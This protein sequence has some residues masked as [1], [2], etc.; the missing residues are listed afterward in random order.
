MISFQEKLADALWSIME[1]SEG[2][3]IVIGKFG[4]MQHVIAGLK[5]IDKQLSKKA[6][7][8]EVP[9]RKIALATNP[10]MLVT[11]DQASKLYA[12]GT[13]NCVTCKY[14]IA[15]QQC[16]QW[17][18][19]NKHVTINQHTADKFSLGGCVLQRLIEPLT[20]GNFYIKSTDGPD[21]DDAFDS[22]ISNDFFDS[23]VE[24]AV[25]RD[26]VI[27]LRDGKIKSTLSKR[28]LNIND[29]LDIEVEL[30]DHQYR[31]DDDS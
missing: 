29:E 15:N 11:L 10:D 6:S 22:N 25:D 14:F 7:H 18:K 31:P 23:I 21:D 20:D 9:D 24:L 26:R 12:T 30:N 4:I 27:I 3:T 1:G 17:A 16:P 28:D 2:R 13:N 8:P 5:G 19:K